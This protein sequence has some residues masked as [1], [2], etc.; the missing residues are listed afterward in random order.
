VESFFSLEFQQK[1]IASGLCLLFPFVSAS[2]QVKGSKILFSG[3]EI[4]IEVILK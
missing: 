4:I 2:V 1:I 3:E